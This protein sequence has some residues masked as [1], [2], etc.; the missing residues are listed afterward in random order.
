ME[1]MEWMEWTEWMDGWMDGWMDRMDGWKGW[2][3]DDTIEWN[4]W[5]AWNGRNGWNGWPGCMEWIFGF[6]SPLDS[7][8]P[9][10]RLSQTSARLSE[11]GLPCN[12]FFS[13]SSHCRFAHSFLTS[14]NSYV[15]FIRVHAFQWKSVSPLT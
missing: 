2:L 15:I 5:N 8:K 14:S 3:M 10:I 11:T 9:S 4:A 7:M 12:M 6:V 13:C 1:C